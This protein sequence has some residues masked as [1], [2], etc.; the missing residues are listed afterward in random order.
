MHSIQSL[1]PTPT[2][3]SAAELAKQ[4][5]VPTPD[6]SL[7]AVTVEGVS[8]STLDLEPGWAFVGI[9]GMREHGARR[10]LEAKQIG[11]TLLIT[12]SEGAQIAKDAG[13]PIVLVEDP[14]A[15]AAPAAKALHADAFK[16]LTLVGVTG[17]NGKTTTTYLLRAAL[18]PTISPMGIIGTLEVEVGPHKITAERTTNEAPVIYRA[19]AEAAEGG[20][21]GVVVEVSSHALELNRADGLKFD[22]AVFTNLQHDHLDLH[23]TMDGYYAAKAQLFSPERAKA[24]VVCVDDKYGRRLAKEARIPVVAVQA[25]TDDDPGVEVP[26]WTVVDISPNAEKFGTDFTLVDPEGNRTAAFCPIPGLVNV[27]NAAAAIVGSHVLGTPLS[28]AVEATGNAPSIPG[29]MQAVPALGAHQPRVIVDYAHTPE[30]IKQLLADFRELTAGNLVAVFG[31][32]GDRDASKREP[33]AEITAETADVLWVTDENPRYE[34][35]ASIREELLRGV[36]RIRP[37]L[38]DVTEVTTSRR[39]AIREAIMAAGPD[40]TVLIFGKGA[41]PYQE[42][43]GVKHSF[44]DAS[45]VEEV[46]FATR[47]KLGD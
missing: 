44:L 4:L 2:P 28:E 14:R 1:R 41:E 17:T 11:A 47:N 22:L 30:A 24:G 37:N 46:L 19:L 40:D 10:A 36:R 7:N 13:L 18:A 34:D 5:G 27:Q 39:D 35:A 6:S 42:V 9:P 8:V 12:D 20:Q 16:N 33:L 38:E 3:I 31:T 26:V 29:R 21:K 23:K 25:L 32:D 45:V 15:S 43:Q